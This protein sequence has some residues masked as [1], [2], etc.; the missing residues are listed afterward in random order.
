MRR[1]RLLLF[2]AAGLAWAAGSAAGQESLDAARRRWELLPKP[3]Q[4]RI[5]RNYEVWKRLTPLEKARLREKYARF[6]KLPPR[7][8]DS[9]RLRHKQRVEQPR[10]R[11]VEPSR[12]ETAKPRAK[13]AERR[14]ERLRQERRDRLDREERRER[15]R[16]AE[17]RMHRPGR[18]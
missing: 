13:A 4:E 9:L 10:K 11:S 1:A 12:P 5:L 14:D 6:E 7:E 17:E 8:R 15:R 3:E 2:L 16:A 18:R